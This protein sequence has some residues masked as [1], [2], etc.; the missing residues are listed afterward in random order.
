MYFFVGLCLLFL[1]WLV[2]FQGVGSL[3][4]RKSYFFLSWCL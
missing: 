4:V 1:G 3:F 2:L